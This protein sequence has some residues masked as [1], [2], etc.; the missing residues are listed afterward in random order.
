MW[1]VIW[2]VRKPTNI[3]FLIRFSV[4]SQKLSHCIFKNYCEI[5]VISFWSLVKLLHAEISNV[6]TDEI[7]N[8]ENDRQVEHIVQEVGQVVAHVDDRSIPQ[9]EDLLA[10]LEDRKKE[11]E[12]LQATRSLRQAERDEEARKMKEELERIR[13]E[14]SAQQLQAGQQIMEL[15]AILQGFF[16]P[17]Y[18]QDSFDYHY[19]S[20]VLVSWHWMATDA[21]SSSKQSLR[22][23]TMSEEDEIHTRRSMEGLWSSSILAEKSTDLPADHGFLDPE[24]DQIILT[25]KTQ[26]ESANEVELQNAAKIKE[27]QAKVDS[28]RQVELKCAS[29]LSE[30]QS[31]L[32]SVDKAAS[33]EYVKTRDVLYILFVRT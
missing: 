23:H 11:I 31:K 32:D 29:K 2:K 26:L 6:T 30:M 20:W 25:L 16:S 21:M 3:L 9:M 28:A 7:E 15:R 17:F 13:K 27:L 19:A 18:H 33:S 12:R 1:K 22:P 24:K 14:C 5:V 4:Q 10:R 8:L